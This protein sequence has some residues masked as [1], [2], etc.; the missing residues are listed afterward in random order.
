M[1][2]SKTLAAR[3]KPARRKPRRVAAA[4]AIAAILLAGAFL[5]AHMLVTRWLLSG[6][7]LRA[8][9]N[10]SPETTL[11]EY[12]E[13]VST[14]P[15]TLRLKNLR[16]RGSDANVEWIVRLA[17]ARAEYSILALLSRT[18]RVQRVSGSGL[19][20][21]LRQKLDRRDAHHLPAAELPP[22]EGFSDPPW[23]KPEPEE[24]AAVDSGDPWTVEVG[25]IGI[26]RFEE[27]WLDGYHFEGSARLRGAFRLR[28]G[29]LARVGPADVDFASG[30]LRVAGHPLLDAVAGGIHAAIAPW[31]PR[32]VRG[33]AVWR[34]VDAR[35][36]FHGPG[37]HLDF[38][39]A[40]LRDSR[41]PRFEG[42]QGVFSAQGA[43]DRGKASGR[44]HLASRGGRARLSGLQLTG[45]ARVSLRIPS[46]D[47]ERGPVD[48]SGSALQ[49]TDVAASGAADSR[50]WWARLDLPKARVRDGLEADLKLECRDA[51]PLLAALGVGLPRW[52]RGLLTLEGLTAEAGVMLASARTRVRG[53]EARGGKFHILGEYARDGGDEEG[54][55]LL[56]SGL[57]RVGVGAGGRAS[58]RVFAPRRW[59]VKERALLLSSQ[60][61]VDVDVESRARQP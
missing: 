25:G 60:E 23:R 11:I 43:I 41:E 47:L 46:W 51:R 42:G 37:G 59:Y 19:T 9:I 5:L 18:F 17:E 50:E 58:V 8:W 6:P 2:K 1:R 40:F 14:V 61:D 33:G 21:R 53:L 16:I 39:N 56:E 48:L 28:P 55:F 26:D 36:D 49:L 30:T 27:I 54:V 29:R 12:D 22:I 44:A 57:L 3:R 35:I 32:V 34:N 4:L 38:L 24:P 52:T 10:T 13:A 31:D 15:G 20:F 45:S 7:R